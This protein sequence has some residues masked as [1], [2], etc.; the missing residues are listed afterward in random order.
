MTE[1][2]TETVFEIDSC[3][4][5]TLPYPSPCTEPHGHRWKVTVKCRAGS[6]DENGMVIDFKEIKEMLRWF[7][8]TTINK[9][10]PFD[11][12]NPTAE[13]LARYWLDAINAHCA[14]RPHKPVCYEVSVQETPGNKAV[15]RQE[16]GK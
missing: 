5:L 1:W 7:D 6:L 16:K 9:H 15:Y 11:T 14:S 3:H 12:A 4:W 2:L 13:N 8:H 10:P